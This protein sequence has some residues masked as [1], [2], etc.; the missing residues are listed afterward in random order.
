MNY[1]N[2]SSIEENGYREKKKIN[3]SSEEQRKVVACELQMTLVGQNGGAVEEGASEY[4]EQTAR[5]HRST[6][7]CSKRVLSSAY[8][9][10]VSQDS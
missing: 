5:K 2:R 10:A 3:R 1:I 6:E 7:G 9:A 8:E 4:N